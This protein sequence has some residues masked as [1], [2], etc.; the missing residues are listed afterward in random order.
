MDTRTYGRRP[1]IHLLTCSH[2]KALRE[3]IPLPENRD[4]G[5]GF[6]TG[7]RVVAARVWLHRGHL[8]KEIR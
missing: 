2:G 4:E 6:Q 8:E 5:V 1:T 3:E 7:N